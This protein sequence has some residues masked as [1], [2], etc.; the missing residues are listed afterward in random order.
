M[1]HEWRKM[2]AY[3]LLVRKPEGRK[4]LGRP[5][6]RWVYSIRIDLGEVGGGGMDWIGL[7]R[8]RIG[9]GGGL[10]LTQ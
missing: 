7:F 4:A 2:M 8:L 10:L 6:R 9:T 1:W 5:R 3:M